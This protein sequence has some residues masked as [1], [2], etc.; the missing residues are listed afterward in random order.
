MIAK[1]TCPHILHHKLGLKKFHLR[2]APHS[3][4][5]NQRSERVAYSSLLL[6]ALEKAQRKGFERLITGDESWF[7]LSYPDQ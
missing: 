1:S 6:V 7:D 2:W 3:L 4:S 5:V